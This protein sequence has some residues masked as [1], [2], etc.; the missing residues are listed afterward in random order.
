VRE[1]CERSGEAWSQL[2]ERAER[3]IAMRQEQ[4]DFKAKQVAE[5]DYENELEY[6]HAQPALDAGEDRRA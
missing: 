2:A 3:Q 6:E 4:E 5:R 1:R